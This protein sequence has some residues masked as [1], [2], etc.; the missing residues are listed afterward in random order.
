MPNGSTPA[1]LARVTGS[2]EASR[3]SQSCSPQWYAS[4]GSLRARS[5]DTQLHSAGRAANMASNKAAAIDTTHRIPYVP[6]CRVD[7]LCHSPPLGN[8]D[9]SLGIIISPFVANR[10]EKTHI[11]SFRLLTPQQTLV[12][13]NFS[14]H[15]AL[16]FQCLAELAAAPGLRR[17]RERARKS[18]KA[19]LQRGA[20]IICR[21][22]RNHCN[23][24][25][26]RRPDRCTL[27]RRVARPCKGTL[28]G[29]R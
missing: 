23:L 25:I 20:Y 8:V 22:V 18:N 24:C 5:L 13:Q 3:R 12:S 1:R 10:L 7:C 29:R 6:P 9:L 16:T 2:R 4:L 28:R 21:H 15:N 26:F 27:A 14:H 17:R 19:N 11:T